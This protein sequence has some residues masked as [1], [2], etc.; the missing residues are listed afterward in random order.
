MYPWTGKNKIKY[1]RTP[2]ASILALGAIITSILI[3][4]KYTQEG[5]LN[6]SSLTFFVTILIVIILATISYKVRADLYPLR[7]GK[8]FKRYFLYLLI[9][10]LI[11]L[12]LTAIQIL[13]IFL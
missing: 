12:A 7:G 13:P 1:P 9:A 8:F 5:L 10:I 4:R 11:A 3:Y 2:S 6:P